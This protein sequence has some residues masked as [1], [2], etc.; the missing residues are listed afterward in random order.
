[1]LFIAPVVGGILSEVV[2]EKLK[3][4]NI[5]FVINRK[6][7]YLKKYTKTRISG[8]YNPYI[9]MPAVAQFLDW[10]LYEFRLNFVV[11]NLHKT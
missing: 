2:K 10:S 8:I 3:I 4:G 11:P 6:F 5:M 7:Q 9:T 1:M